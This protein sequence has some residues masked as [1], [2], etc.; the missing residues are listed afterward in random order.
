MP[1]LLHWWCTI[2]GISEQAVRVPSVLGDAPLTAVIPKFIALL[3]APDPRPPVWI[4][5]ALGLAMLCWGIVRLFYEERRVFAL[6]VMWMLSLPLTLWA[7]D[8]VGGTRSLLIGRYWVVICPPLYILMAAGA[9]RISSGRR[10]RW[11]PVAIAVT[12]CSLGTLTA[13]GHLRPFF[14]ENDDYRALVATAVSLNVPILTPAGTAISLGLGY[15]HK[16]NQ[17]LVQF[18]SYRPDFEREFSQYSS[19]LLGGVLLVSGAE[20]YRREDTAR[21]VLNSA[22]LS[23]KA[24]YEWD[25]TRAEYFTRPYWLPSKSRVHRGASPRVFGEAVAGRE[26]G[27]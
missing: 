15:Y 17:Q 11:I 26:A 24:S 18:R 21:R 3:I 8:L 12:V 27:Q 19:T 2:A 1:Y 9:A 5:T 10:R 22:G 7:V 6:C 16:V 20:S 4:I 13:A 25:H 14:S 23:I